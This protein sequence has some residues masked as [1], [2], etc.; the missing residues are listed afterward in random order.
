[1]TVSPAKMAETIEMPSGV[2]LDG[3]KELCIRWGS[4]ASR[5]ATG[6][7]ILGAYAPSVTKYTNYVTLR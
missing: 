1:M 7:G 6:M 5:S 2:D 3:P 4:G